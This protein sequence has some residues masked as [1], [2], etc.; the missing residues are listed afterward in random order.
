MTNKIILS[1]VSII[2]CYRLYCTGYKFI[3]M[4]LFCIGLAIGIGVFLSRIHKNGFK[5]GQ[6]MYKLYKLMIV[7]LCS[8]FVLIAS[9]VFYDKYSCRNIDN[10]NYNY[11]LVLGSALEDSKVSNILAR[12]L[13]VAID[14]YNSH[15][16]VQLI[17]SGGAT[18]NFGITE[19]SAMFDYLVDK[20]VN[21]D[22]IILEEQALSTFENIKYSKEILTSLGAQNEKILIVTSDFHIHRAMMIADSFDL[23]NSGLV[24]VVSNTSKINYY[25]REF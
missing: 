7:S 8:I 10:S 11:V 12:R 24:S 15:T 5:Y 23:E 9:L 20:G 4:F 17:V 2:V 13:D 25:L 22:S 14:Y 19:A 21:P 6:K 3:A 18:N 1:L 16:N